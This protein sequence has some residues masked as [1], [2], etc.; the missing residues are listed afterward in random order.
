MRKIILLLIVGFAVSFTACNKLQFNKDTSDPRIIKNPDPAALASR[1]I[2]VNQ[3]VVWNNNTKSTSAV[4]FDAT[5]EWNLESMQNPYGAQ[6]FLSASSVEFDNDIVYVGFHDRGAEF[7]G[8]L[9]AIHKLKNGGVSNNDFKLGEIQFET[10]DIN[11]VEMANGKLW[12]AGESFKRGSEGLRFDVTVDGS[13]VPDLTA[14]STLIMP[15][16]GVSANSITSIGNEVWISSGSAVN[17]SNNGGLLV[18]DAT[19]TDPQTI[20]YLKIER[21][22]AKHFDAEGDFGVWLFGNGTGVSHMYLYNLAEL[23]GDPSRYVDVKNAG[24]AYGVTAFGKNAVDVWIDDRAADA[25]SDDGRTAADVTAFPNGHPYAFCAMGADGVIKVDLATTPMSVVYDTDESGMF[26]LANGVKTDGTYVY[27]A[28]GAD[29]LLVYSMD[30]QTLL[31]SYDGDFNG[32]TNTSDGSCN[33]VDIEEI[34]ANNS[35]LYAAFGRG[36]MVKISITY[37]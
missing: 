28:H 36:G 12:V 2:I 1:L 15:I 35:T 24:L 29:G 13:G 27:V 5:V 31:A 33:Y 19:A 8:N 11:D 20:P 37:P 4:I 14:A 9:V 26:G 16:S 3:P 30:L 22:N 25:N 34:D 10:I 18:V 23:E 7:Y 32:D 17:G 21:E 6:D